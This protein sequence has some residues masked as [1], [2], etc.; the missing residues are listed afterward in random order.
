[1]NCGTN[2]QFSDFFAFNGYSWCDPSTYSQSG[3][4]Q[5]VEQYS[6]Y[7]IPL[8]LSE[9]GCITNKRQFQEVATLYS[10][11]MTSVYSD[12]L[13]YEYSEEG[14]GY[15]LVTINGNFAPVEKSDFKALM[16]AFFNTKSPAGAGGAKPNGSPSQCAKHSKTWEVT[17]FQ[18]ADLPSIS[19]G[20]QKYMSKGAGEAPG[21]NGPGSQ[22]A[23]GTSTGTSKAG[24]GQVSP[25]GSSAA[26]SL[27][28][29][30][31]IFKPLG[32]CGVAVFL[33]TLLGAAL[34]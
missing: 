21:L 23:G 12:V 4:D 30:D 14:S 7:S 16:Q 9:Y 22:N 33:N 25:S 10:S 31:T 17:D 27:L 19:T 11:Q 8:F 3:W 26:N 1:M 32:A 20:A 6:S 29:P 5:K 28:K 13:V 15:G 18:G 2:D 34:F 24:S